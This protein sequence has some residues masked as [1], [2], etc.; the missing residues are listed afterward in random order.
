MN[1]WCEYRE[2]V[3]V[4]PIR[5]KK[6]SGKQG[7]LVD[8]GFPVAIADEV[9]PYT[10][11][12]LQFATTDE[13]ADF[14]SYTDGTWE[15]DESTEA[16]LDAVAVDPA[17]PREQGGYYWGYTVRRATSL[18]AVF[19]DC[20]FEDGYDVSIGTSERGETVDVDALPDEVKHVLVVFGGVA[21]LEVAVEN[22]EALREKG[23]GR[24]NVA[25]LFD[26]YVNVCERQ[27]SRT[28]RTEEA[29]WTAL[30]R[31]SSWCERVIR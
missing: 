22:D 16:V 12:T 7:T 15:I 18:S 14:Q 26:Y 2:G 30:G 17:Q 24:E 8:A 6:G 5:R 1:E 13:P 31:M 19:T 25:D 23:V 9:P 21:G 29:V 11:L 27:G 20:P 4:A 10:R 28:M 3:T